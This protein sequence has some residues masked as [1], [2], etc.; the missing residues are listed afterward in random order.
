MRANALGLVQVYTLADVNGGTYT[1]GI[2]AGNISVTTNFCILQVTLLGPFTIRFTSANANGTAFR[3]R[4]AAGNYLP[5]SVTFYTQANAAGTPYALSSGVASQSFST[6]LTL[7]VCVQNS[8]QTVFTSTNLSSA[9]AGTY[10][11]TLTILV[12]AI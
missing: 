10:T 12:T 9:K 11:D 7:G 2:S 6:I 3:A 4:S 1:P 5:Y 8:F